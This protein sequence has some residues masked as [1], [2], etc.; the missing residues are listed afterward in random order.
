[1]TVRAPELPRELEP[2]RR[3]PPGDPDDELELT[4]AHVEAEL[5]LEPRR[6]RIRECELQG[7]TL[8]AG[9]VR[10][11]SLIDTILADCDLSNVD[12]REGR[13][14]RIEAHRSRLVGFALSGGGVQDARFVDCTL[15]LGAFAA[16][17]LRDVTFQGVDLVECSFLEARLQ[18]VEFVD[19]RLAGAD[20]RGAHLRDCTIRGSSLDG[21][22]GVSSLRGVR[23]PWADVLGS[24]DAL[25]A[26]LGI[27]IAED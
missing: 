16:S 5:P 1:M 17:G 19:C 8:A 22:L 2:I 7:V 13:L 6:L 15:Q 20:F 9:Q 10:G 18:G 3:L 26:A 25:A 21:V 24:A 14:H 23:M 4:G 11:L 12:A 27:E